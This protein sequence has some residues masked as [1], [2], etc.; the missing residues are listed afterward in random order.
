MY[1]EHY[2]GIEEDNTWKAVSMVPG[3]QGAFD[4]C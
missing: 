4:K 3:T 1:L 2:G